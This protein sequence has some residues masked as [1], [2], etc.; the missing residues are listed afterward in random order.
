MVCSSFLKLKISMKLEEIRIFTLK[1]DLE[2]LRPN[3]NSMLIPCR[4]LGK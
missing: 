4:L 1:F 2:N 3:S